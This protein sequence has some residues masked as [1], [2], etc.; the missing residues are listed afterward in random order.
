MSREYIARRTAYAS[1]KENEY[2]M[3]RRLALEAGFDPDEAASIAHSAA[4][5]G[6]EGVLSGD[7]RTIA[8]SRS[9]HATGPLSGSSG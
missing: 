2:D 6:G 4:Y 9:K 7:S 1:S 3:T 5:G 8:H